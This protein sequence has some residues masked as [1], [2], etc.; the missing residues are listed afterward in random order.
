MRLLA[1][2]DFSLRLLMHLARMHPDPSAQPPVSTQALAEA[3]DVPR[4][5]VHKIVQDLAEAGFVRTFRGPQGGVTLAHDP[6]TIAVGTVIRHLESRQAIVE[7]FRP[8]GGTCC[9]SPHCRL[10]GALARAQTQFLA[11]LDTVTIADCLP[12]PAGG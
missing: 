9:F 6:A 10:R 7:C 12:A 5:H 8:D 11:S 3:I 2:T 4:N 1:S